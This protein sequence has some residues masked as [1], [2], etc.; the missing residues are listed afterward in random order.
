MFELQPCPF[1]ESRGTDL[2]VE[3]LNFAAGYVRCKHCGARG[4][5]GPYASVIME[6][7]API[8][9][10]TLEALDA[11]EPEAGEQYRSEIAAAEFLEGLAASRLEGQFIGPLPKPEV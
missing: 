1:C 3:Q 11:I 7:F 5:L 9:Q 10:Q 2:V 4:P 6:S 8:D